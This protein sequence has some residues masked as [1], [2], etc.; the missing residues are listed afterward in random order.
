MDPLTQ[1]ALGAALPQSVAT[2]QLMGLAMLCGFAGGMAPDLDVLIRSESDPLLF[3]EYHR[4]FTHSL[5][6]IPIG[7]AL[8]ALTL[9]ALIGRRRAWTLKR[10]YLFTVLG[11][12]THALLDACTTYGTLL[13]WPFSH[14]RFAWNNVSIIDPLLTLPLLL[15]I[16][17]ARIARR[18]WPAML[19]MGWVL[20][21]LFLGVLARDAA[22]E[23]GYELA[24]SRGHDPVLLSA[25]PSFANLLLWKVVYRDGSHYYVDAI[26][27]GR[28]PLI[29]PG[30]SVPVLNVARDFPWLETGS[31]QAVDIERFRWFSMDYLAVDPD[32]RHRVIDIRYSMLPNEI[33]ALWGITLDPATQHSAHVRYT[34]TRDSGDENLQRLWRMLRGLPLPGPGAAPL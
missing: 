32:N 14:Q 11:Y 1:G 24:A 21:Y 10:I 2:R 18:R 8:V 3:L 15:L 9:W 34:V 17:A 29:Y 26:R 20:G 25:K 23:V 16:V 5:I 13:L 6:F 12:A 33:R 7:A 19:G 28:Q 27:L 4:Q 30:S 22:A 31:R